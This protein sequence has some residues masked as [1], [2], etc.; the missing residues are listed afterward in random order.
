MKDIKPG[1]LSKIFELVENDSIE[2]IDNSQLKQLLAN[3]IQLKECLIVFAHHNYRD[4]TELNENED[5][6]RIQNIIE[7]K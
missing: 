5:I 2:Q 3:S 1:V 4:D 7:F 6:I